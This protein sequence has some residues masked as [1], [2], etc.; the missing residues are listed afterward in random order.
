MKTLKDI[1]EVPLK[2]L[3][4]GITQWVEHSCRFWEEW[5]DNYNV[6]TALEAGE[7]ESDETKAEKQPE[8]RMPTDLKA[9]IEYNKAVVEKYQTTGAESLLKH[10]VIQLSKERGVKL[11]YIY[12]TGKTAEDTFTEELK[13]AIDVSPEKREILK[14]PQSNR[15]EFVARKLIDENPDLIERIRNGDKEVVKE[16]DRKAIEMSCGLVSESDLKFALRSM[17]RIK[18]SEGV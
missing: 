10:L 6:S 18:L 14:V 9:V 13:A 4:K 17:I 11:D 12:S 16:F 7:T 5:L 1:L 8:E 2:D 15:A 3:S